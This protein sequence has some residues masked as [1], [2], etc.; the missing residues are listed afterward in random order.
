LIFGEERLFIIESPKVP[1]GI[2]EFILKFVGTEPRGIKMKGIFPQ[3]W[4][5]EAE[6]IVGPLLF[7]E[8]VVYEV[9][10]IDY[11]NNLLWINQVF[12]QEL[13]QTL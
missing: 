8:D 3:I 13:N 2:G 4:A 10:E 5:I 9:V 7:D 11:K 6:K 12:D 1:S